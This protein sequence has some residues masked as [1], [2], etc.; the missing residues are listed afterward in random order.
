MRR[1][2]R[3][4]ARIVLINLRVHGGLPIGL[5]GAHQIKPADQ[6]GLPGGLIGPSG[7]QVGLRTGLPEDL[8]G[9]L[10]NP[11]NQEGLP[12][13]PIV[14]TGLLDGLR[15]GLPEDLQG[16]LTN[17]I[18]QEELPGDPIVP[19]GHQ[20]EL[21]VIL[22]ERRIGRIDLVDKLQDA[23]INP[24]GAQVTTNRDG[25]TVLEGHLGVQTNDL[26]A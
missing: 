17:P 4:G 13:S 14:P 3:P 19:I 23:H 16:D 5:Q 10:T 25:H 22:A 7:L 15:T 18:N 6:E 9:D 26:A 20:G 21:P 24:G 8:Q 2:E 1:E 11:I 12:G